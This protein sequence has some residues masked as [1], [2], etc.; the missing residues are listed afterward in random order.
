M[1]ERASSKAYILPWTL[2]YFH[3]CCGR[4]THLA[5][6]N[7]A[8]CARIWHKGANKTRQHPNDFQDRGDSRVQA[9]NKRLADTLEQRALVG[10]EKQSIR[11]LEKWEAK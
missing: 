10:L 1:E 11:I 6:Q 4:S 5:Y 2:A 9:E 3:C 7:V 8:T